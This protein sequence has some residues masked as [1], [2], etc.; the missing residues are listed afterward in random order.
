MPPELAAQLARDKERERKRLLARDEARRALKRAQRLRPSI[1]LL[2]ASPPT[3]WLEYVGRSQASLR[4]ALAACDAAI[5]YLG[6]AGLP[7]RDF[8]AVRAELWAVQASLRALQPVTICPACRAS[9]P[10][11]LT[12]E[13]RGTLTVAQAATIPPAWLHDE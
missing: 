2:G 1:E 11:C 5:R 7:R 4:S 12:C 9:D 3:A 10:A 13:G 8:L 6:E